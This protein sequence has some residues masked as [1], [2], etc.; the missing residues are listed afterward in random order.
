M[1]AEGGGK[2][3]QCHLEQQTD[4]SLNAYHFMDAS[5]S[6]PKINI[7]NFAYKENSL[8]LTFFLWVLFR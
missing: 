3:L 4:C 8:I 2:K 6:L 7:L 1:T 5:V